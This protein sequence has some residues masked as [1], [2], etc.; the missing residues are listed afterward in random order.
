MKTTGDY[1][2]DWLVSNGQ[3][4]TVKNYIQLNWCGDKTL[5]DLEA[6]ELAEV[7]FDMLVDTD[8][9]FVN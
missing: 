9:E 3:P 7:P 8:S 4:L 1:T 6:E 2:L 5:E